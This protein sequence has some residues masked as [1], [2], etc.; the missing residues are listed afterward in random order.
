MS[1][2][3]C[4]IN[5]CVCMCVCVRVSVCISLTYLILLQVVFYYFTRLFFIILCYI[6]IYCT[7]DCVADV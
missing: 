2:M 6:E 5:M 4:C 1:L 3:T 7:K